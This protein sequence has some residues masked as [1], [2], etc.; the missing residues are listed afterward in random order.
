MGLE[1][2]Y[3]PHAFLRIFGYILIEEVKVYLNLKIV[4]I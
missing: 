1:L 2:P 3:I 4:F